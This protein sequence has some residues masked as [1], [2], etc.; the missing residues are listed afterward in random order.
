MDMENV[1]F[2]YF[3]LFSIFR[4]WLRCFML[5]SCT[6][7]LFI[8]I[9]FMRYYGLKHLRCISS[10]SKLLCRI[11]KTLIDHRSNCNKFYTQRQAINRRRIR[12]RYRRKDNVTKLQNVLGFTFYNFGTSKEIQLSDVIGKNRPRVY[13][14]VETTLLY[15]LNQKKVCIC[16]FA[17]FGLSQ[18]LWPKALSQLEI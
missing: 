3:F 1:N 11:P 15:G 4:F 2:K 9:I 7:I 10:D 12:F 17:T 18:L 16:Y 14:Y 13:K 8:Y 5:Y 6:S